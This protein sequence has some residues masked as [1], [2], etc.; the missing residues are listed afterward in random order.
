M[1]PTEMDTLRAAFGELMGAER[2]L[3]GRDPRHAQIRVLVQLA[4][5]EE[6]TA[7]EL[8]KRAELSPGAMTAMLDQLEAKEMVSRRRSETD[9]RQ[10]IVRMTDAGQEKL[11]SKRALWERMWEDGLAEHSEAELR[12]AAAV[13]RTIAGVLD[14]VGVARNENGVLSP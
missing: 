6:V 1:T 11:K 12:T 2:R 7:G 5:D 13:M 14:Q 4:K 9:R 10:V 8:A 3:R